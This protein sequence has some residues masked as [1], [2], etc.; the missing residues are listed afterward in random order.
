MFDAQTTIIASFDLTKAKPSISIITSTV[1][2]ANISN[3]RP[4]SNFM[5]SMVRMKKTFLF[6]EKVAERMH[7]IWRK[8]IHGSIDPQSRL[9]MSR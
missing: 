1:R 4:M 6:N 2:G 8:L 5:K 9:C 7:G 3:Q